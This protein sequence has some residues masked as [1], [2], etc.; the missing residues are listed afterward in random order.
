MAAT[1]YGNFPLELL[2]GNIDF[3]T[4][5]VKALL[6]DSTYVFDKDTHTHLDDINAIVGAEVSG[7]GYTAGGV[8]VTGV[9]TS[10]DAANDRAVLDADDVAFGT[11]TLTDVTGIIFYV[12]VGGV[13]A[14]SPLISHDSFAAQAP[15]AV[16]FTYQ[17]NAAGIV[18][19]TC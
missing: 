4:A 11:V 15:D 14:S 17:I 19:L 7:T 13:A 16:T 3:D 8:A 6:V 10:Y 2:K 12:D 9:I 18:T 5:A 1:A